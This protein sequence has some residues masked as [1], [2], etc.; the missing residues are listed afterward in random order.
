MKILSDKRY[1][2]MVK[3]KQELDI[4]HQLFRRRKGC[5][6]HASKEAY[7]L[8]IPL[9]SAT[10]AIYDVMDRYFSERGL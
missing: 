10:N 3:A 5:G 8:G 2:E 4:L 1:D 7:R 6:N 9:H